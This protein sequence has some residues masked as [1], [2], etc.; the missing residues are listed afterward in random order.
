MMAEPMAGSS[1]KSFSDL[2]EMPPLKEP[3]FA[4][5]TPEPDEAS[6]TAQ[7]VFPR[8]IRGKKRSQ[9]SSRGKSWK[10]H[11]RKSRPFHHS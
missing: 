2:A 7:Q 11:S 9:E 4:P 3:V 8:K 10:W 1:G 5:P 6:R